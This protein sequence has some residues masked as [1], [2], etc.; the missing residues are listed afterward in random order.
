MLDEQ[1]KGFVRAGARL[2]ADKKERLKEINQKVDYV[3]KMLREEELR[4]PSTRTFVEN[5]HSDREQ[6][7]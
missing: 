7:R 1:H 2:P 5:E 3:I 4:F 6:K